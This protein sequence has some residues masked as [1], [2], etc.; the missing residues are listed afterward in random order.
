MM[1]WPETM[2]KDSHF[3]PKFPLI[4][5]EGGSAMINRIKREVWTKLLYKPEK[6]AEKQVVGKQ[7]PRNDNNRSIDSPWN[8]N[9]PDNIPHLCFQISNLISLAPKISGKKPY[10]II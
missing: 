2:K 7:L 6:G 1:I 9:S 10:A 4:L 3:Q 5:I 8:D